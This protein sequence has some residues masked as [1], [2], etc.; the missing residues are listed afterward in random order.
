MYESLFPF[1]QCCHGGILNAENTLL[2]RLDHQEWKYILIQYN[3]SPPEYS[4]VTRNFTKVFCDM[5]F[6][7]DMNYSLISPHYNEGKMKPTTPC[8]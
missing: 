5:I 2:C 4:S 7:S 3:I 8:S 6:C 1:H